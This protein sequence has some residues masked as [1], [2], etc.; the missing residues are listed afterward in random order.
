[1]TIHI[2]YNPL[3]WSEDLD[4]TQEEYATAVESTKQNILNTIRNYRNQLLT[5]CDWTQIADV[6]LTTEQKSAW[7]TYRQQLRDFPSTLNMEEHFVLNELDFPS[8]PE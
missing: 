3:E 1:M 4:L 5:S 7:S 2:S 6:D 8:K